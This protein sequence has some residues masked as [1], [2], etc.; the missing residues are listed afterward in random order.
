M[1]R[2]PH[3]PII[4]PEKTGPGIP[5]RPSLQVWAEVEARHG[6]V[7]SL[8]VE[9]SSLRPNVRVFHDLIYKSA[10]AAG[11]DEHYEEFG[12]RLYVLGLVRVS[13]VVAELFADL[14]KEDEGVQAI[15][16]AETKPGPL[17]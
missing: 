3:A 16:D 11:H 6:P 10:R 2:D 8:W 4:L 9:F 14:F 7:G 17:A 5:L 12:R 15:S 13:K 1:R